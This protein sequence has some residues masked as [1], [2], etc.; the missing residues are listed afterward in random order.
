MS[1]LNTEGSY[2]GMIFKHA[3]YQ[4]MASKI[5]ALWQEQWFKEAVIAKWNTIYGDNK[6]IDLQALLNT[7]VD[8]LAA[9]IAQTQAD[10]YA[11]TANGGAGWTLNGEYDAAVQ[12]IKDYLTERFPY[13]DTKF[14]E[15]SDVEPVEILELIDGEPYTYT[16]GQ[17]VERVTYTRKFNYANALNA[18]F[19][20]FNY[21]ITEKD[22]GNFTFYDINMIAASAEIGG[23]VVDENAMYIY[24]VKM[25]PGNT[26]YANNPYL[27]KPSKKY[28]NGYV[29]ELQDVELKAPVTNSTL[30]LET[31]A[32]EYDFYGCYNQYTPK[33]NGEVYWMAATGSLS[34]CLANS[35]MKS[36][37]WYIKATSKSGGSAK[38]NFIFEEYD[39]DAT[40]ISITSSN[41]VLESIYS[42]NG[43]LLEKPRKGLNIIRMK[44][45]TT[46]KIMVR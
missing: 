27:I 6:T 1:D 31:R 7:K 44:N 11:A 33:N 13:L 40:G 15:L 20:P 18:W 16:A 26:L 42:P 23:E 21:T 46:R 22:A 41:E 9:E 43:M 28:T 8:A 38:V 25:K 39:P 17:M 34:P 37:R 19:V 10:N 29:F 14:K 3:K 2:N 5:E 36:Y 35:T 24:I 30:H 45:G 12:S 4:V 32:N